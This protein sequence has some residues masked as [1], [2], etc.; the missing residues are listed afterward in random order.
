MNSKSVIVVGAGSAGSVVARRLVDA[1][2]KVT[3]FEA[4]GEDT[5][6]AI[7]DLSRLGELW[8]S[9]D[10]WDYHTAP[11]QGAAKKPM[12]LPRGKVLGGSHALNA[13]IWVRCAPQDFDGWAE[14]SG[15]RWSWRNVLPIYKSIENY[16]EGPSEFHGTDG[17]LPVV[18]DYELDPIQQS[19]VDAAVQSGVKFNPDYNGESLEGVSKEQVNIVDGERINTWKAY[20][21]PV[22]EQLEIITNAEVHSVI[23][24]DGAAVGLRYQQD[25][26]LKELLADEVVLSAGALGSPQI[27]LRS[28]IGPG[29]E[30]EAVGVRPV[31][32]SPQVGKN[33][34]DHLLA[35]VIAQ[36]TTRDID[37]PRTGVSVSQSH[38]F[39]KSRAELEVPDTQPIFF[40]VPMYSPGM[41]MIE[42]T[43]FTLHSGI[44]TPASRGAVTLSGPNLDDPVTID[45]NALDDPQD[46][47]SFLFSIKQCRDIVKQRALAEVWGAVEVYPGPTVQSDAELETYIRN[48]VVTYHHQV[49]TCRMGSDDQAVV[50]PRLKLNGLSGL[51]VID[52]S[53]MPKITTGNTNAPAIL[54]GEL[55]AQFLIEDL[56]L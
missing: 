38:L 12:H 16:S 27:L 18:N 54:I 31:L 40:S 53:I 34:H 37:P 56:E 41:D 46:M 10:D 7:H 2:A 51:R 44:V 39:A 48:N 11:M 21:K 52:A 13:T 25:G 6:P 23:V 22:R 15:E 20:L 24:R 9:P 32:E 3:L 1:G 19:I 49:G 26:E 29:E 36:T 8:Y 35:P 47:K 45:L 5:N 42:G 14:E 33:L 4:G 43:A 50:D 55:G 17:L 28:G 30:L